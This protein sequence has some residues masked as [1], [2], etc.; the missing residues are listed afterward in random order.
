MTLKSANLQLVEEF[1]EYWF[2]RDPRVDG[3]GV[4]DVVYVVLFG[5]SVVVNL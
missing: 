2:I 1:L 5:V 3:W 4:D